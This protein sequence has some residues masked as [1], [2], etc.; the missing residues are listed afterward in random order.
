MS[1]YKSD[2]TLYLSNNIEL[3]EKIDFIKYL[4]LYIISVSVEDFRKLITNYRKCKKLL[5]YVTITYFVFY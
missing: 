3:C 2:C 1:T 4:Y 5:D